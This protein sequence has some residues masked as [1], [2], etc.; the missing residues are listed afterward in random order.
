MGKRSI[1][2]KRPT[3]KKQKD[4]EKAAIKF[5]Q[6]LF[7]RQRDIDPEIQAAINKGLWDTL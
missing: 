4:L 2:V 7:S 1:V 3:K 6:E 5:A